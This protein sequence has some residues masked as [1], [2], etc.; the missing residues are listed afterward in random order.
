MKGS[1][2]MLAVSGWGGREDRGR[3]S[4]NWEEM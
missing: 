4:G 2:N 3:G 1:V